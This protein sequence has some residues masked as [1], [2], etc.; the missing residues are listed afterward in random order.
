MTKWCLFP[1]CD[2]LSMGT[3]TSASPSTSS[4]K[5]KNHVI[6]SINAVKVLDKIQ[7]SCTIKSLSKLETEQNLN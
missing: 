7:H 2:W 6:I 4:L 1:E 5:K 3:S